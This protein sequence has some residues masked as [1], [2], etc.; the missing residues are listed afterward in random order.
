MRT[1]AKRDLEIDLE[2]Y[3]EGRKEP[4]SLQT[5]NRRLEE[6]KNATEADLAKER[7]RVEHLQGQLQEATNKF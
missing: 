1:S 7:A 3:L 5:E 6:T 2:I 4:Y